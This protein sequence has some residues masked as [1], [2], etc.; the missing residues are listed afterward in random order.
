MRDNRYLRD[1]MI[2]RDMRR[3]GR[4]RDMRRDYERRDYRDYEMDYGRYR[5]DM[6]DYERMDRGD[7]RDYR[8]YDYGDYNDYGDMDKEYH[9]HL[10][11]WCDKLKRKDRFGIPKNE[12]INRAKQMGVK[13][14]DYDELE[15][16]TV[17]Y[18]LISDFPKIANEPHVYLSM[19]KEWLEDDD[20]EVSPSEKLCKY[21]YTIVKGE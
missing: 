16:M 2:N 3:G 13:F 11:K 12:L 9:E 5:R 19:A 10:E 7:Y 18:M 8:D 20:I 15:F 6:R 4:G 21:Y 14:E 1:R 17:Y